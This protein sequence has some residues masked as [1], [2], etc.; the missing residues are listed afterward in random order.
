MIMAVKHCRG[1]TLEDSSDFRKRQAGGV[2]SDIH[3]ILQAKDVD[4]GRN[5]NTTAK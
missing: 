5:L 1:Q 4:V 2:V 3:S